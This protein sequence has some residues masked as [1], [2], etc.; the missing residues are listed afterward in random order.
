MFLYT[1]FLYLAAAN[2]NENFLAFIERSKKLC[3][4]WEATLLMMTKLPEKKLLTNTQTLAQF[5]QR[6]RTGMKTMFNSS[7]YE[8]LIP[9][10]NYSKNMSKVCDSFIRNVDSSV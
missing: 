2:H 3:R 1:F 4:A 7:V 8:G 6:V 5:Q 9:K 10:T